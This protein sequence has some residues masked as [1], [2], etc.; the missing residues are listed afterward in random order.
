MIKRIV[1]VVAAA[2][3]L[4]LVLLYGQRRTGPLKVSGFLEADEVRVGSRMGGRVAEVLVAEGA[5][6]TAGARLV[7]LEEFD[8]GHRLE[9]AE[10]ELA[11]RR[12][13]LQ[14]LESGFREEEIA[15]AAA[16]RERLQ[17]KL[18]ALEA[19]PRA[20]EIEAARARQRLAAAQLERAQRAHERNAS[21]ASKDNSV[22]SRDAL[23]RSTEELRVAESQ[24]EV[25]DQELLQLEEGTRAEDL[26]AAR[27]E[28]AEADAA[29]RLAYNGSRPEDIERAAAA[30]KAAEAAV[31]AI[32]SQQDELL[33]V[34][35]VPGVVDVIDLQ[36]GDLVPPNAPVLS[37]IDGNQLWVRAYVPENHL[38][39]KLGQRLYVTV[40]SFPGERFAGELTYVARQAEFT[41]GNVQTP[42][43]RSKQVFRIKVTLREG[44]DRLRPGMAADVW[45]E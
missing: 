19:G 20:E 34:A 7:R 30:V 14:R 35:P 41:P 27:A 36:P 21:L 10:A 9:G 45:L 29:W 42:E 37:L 44:L 33:V 31:A 18:R 2:T 15:Q 1:L 25:R 16:R 39:L 5:H 26:A 40:D 12:A 24:K 22:I 32:R 43:E 38:G 11:G 3:L 17:Q 13:E 4:L 8:L 23:D 6:V 28:W